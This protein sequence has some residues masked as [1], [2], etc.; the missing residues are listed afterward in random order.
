MYD[1]DRLNQLNKRLVLSNYT[2][3]V[4]YNG[5]CIKE[6]NIMYGND[7]IGL[8]TYQKDAIEPLSYKI[9][10]NKLIDFQDGIAI[11]VNVITIIQDF[12]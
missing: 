3:K 11:M 5:V 6:F 2:L 4:K 8:I 1:L 9:N 10:V 12:M 7:I